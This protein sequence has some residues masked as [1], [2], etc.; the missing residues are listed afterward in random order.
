MV[1]LVNK[2]EDYWYVSHDG[3]GHEAFVIR[4]KDND[5]KRIAEEVL[6]VLSCV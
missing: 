3:D 4:L 6:E 1:F 2:C 5:A